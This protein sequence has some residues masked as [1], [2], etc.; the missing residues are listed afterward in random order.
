MWGGETG[1]GRELGQGALMSRFLRAQLRLNSMG[2]SVDRADTPW[3]SWEFPTKGGRTLGDLSSTPHPS[4][5]PGCPGSILSLDI[6]P[7][8]CTGWKVQV[9]LLRWLFGTMS[10]QGLRVGQ[11]WHPAHLPPLGLSCWEVRSLGSLDNGVNGGKPGV[12]KVMLGLWIPLWI[13]N[14]SPSRGTRRSLTHYFRGSSV[15]PALLS[16]QKK[17]HFS[18][19]GQQWPPLW[20]R[21]GLCF[22]GQ[23]Q[24]LFVRHSA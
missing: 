1:K 14:V 17:V 19:L 16:L 15:Y 6:G 5:A 8:P 11:W 22:C 4:P 13:Q 24:P 7:A 20:G 18:S 10:V 12:R 2:T 3:G 23:D 9:L 21:F